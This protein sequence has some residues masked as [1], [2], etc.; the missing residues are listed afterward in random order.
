[1]AVVSIPTAGEEQA[2][3]P[4]VRKQAEAAESKSEE[5]GEK[6]KMSRYHVHEPMA[7][8]AFVCPSASA[9]V[10][11]SSP[12]KP[13]HITP[14]PP[15]ISSSLSFPLA[16]YSD[17]DEKSLLLMDHHLTLVWSQVDVYTLFNGM[18]IQGMS[19]DSHKTSKTPH[20]PLFVSMLRTTKGD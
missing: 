8:P 9:A 11:T 5:T 16:P 20:P 19:H 17:K 14:I 4:G 15:S 2:L 3:A 7:D 13:T 10:R 12:E 18:M 1:M 6:P